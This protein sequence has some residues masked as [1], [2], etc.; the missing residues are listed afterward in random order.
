MGGQGRKRRGQW[1]LISGRGLKGATWGGGAVVKLP[2]VCPLVNS[3]HK[4]G[5][6]EGMRLKEAKEEGKKINARRLN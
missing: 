5:W 3:G 6:R 2:S 4:E 1:R